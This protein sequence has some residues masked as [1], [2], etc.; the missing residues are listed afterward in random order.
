[1]K[2]F[3][4]LFISLLLIPFNFAQSIGA[5]GFHTIIT[6]ADGTVYTWGSNYYGQLGNGTS[7][8]GTNSN[9][10]VA[11]DTS[12][13]LSG[14]TITAVAAGIYRSIA[15]ASDGT[16]YT[17]GWNNSGQLGNGNNTASN[18]PIAV[19]ISGVLSGK[20]IKAVASGEYHSIALASDGTVYT[21]GSNYYGQLGNG[22]NEDSNVP[23]AVDISGVLS[24]KT[25]KAIAAGGYHTI[26]LDSD[27][28]VYSW[29]INYGQLGN[30][31]NIDSNVPV[32]V[33]TS[34]VLSGKTIT[35]VAAGY[36]HSIALDSDGIVYTWGDNDYGQLGNGN[37]TDSN[38]PVATIISGKKIKAIAAGGYH[39]IAL[40]SDGT[41]YTLGSNY[42]GQLGNGN[43]IDSNVPVAVDT[44]GVLS[45]KT[46]TAVTAGYYHSIILVSDGT[47]YTW[48][49]NSEGEL[50]NNENNENSNVPVAVYQDDMGP[51]PVEAAPTVSTEFIL[52]QNYPNPF[53]P[54]TTIKYSIPA[55]PLLEGVRGGLV[56]LKIFNLL[57]QEVATLVNQ[58]QTAGNYEVK[59]D[60]S[61]LASGV[62]LYKLQAGDFSSVRKLI[63]MK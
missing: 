49:R 10:P 32:A 2:K 29:G 19:D 27:G 28:T 62:Y 11:V 60:A 63:L 21:W 44:S 22:N 12:G 37:N 41:V 31:N 23:V 48:G 30:G 47:V 1:M 15:L 61:N 50:G 33:D 5:G 14:K 39:S 34:G 51:L 6:K 18:V 8:S 56:T 38:V 45:G 13:V 57:G 26:A 4:Y 53:N 43:N 25:I 54:V 3:Y 9:V 59:F 35:A 16:V 40:A 46:I 58:Q 36:F 7:G 20:T 17:W 52:S 42:S 55:S 24:G